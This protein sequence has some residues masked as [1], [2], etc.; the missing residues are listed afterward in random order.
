IVPIEKPASE[1]FSKTVLPNSTRQLGVEG[2]IASSAHETAVAT[3]TI[4]PPRMPG[5]LSSF[6]PTTSL[7]ASTLVPPP[8]GS[9]SLGNDVPRIAAQKSDI[10][11]LIAERSISLALADMTLPQGLLNLAGLDPQ[12]R[13]I[14]KAAELERAMSTGRPLVKLRAIYQQ[15]PEF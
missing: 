11:D 7:S 1:R 12:R 9:I 6:S 4:A 14:F 15:A 10:P 2:V 13:L 3:G 8:P 5:I